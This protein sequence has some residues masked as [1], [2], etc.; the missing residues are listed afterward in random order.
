[1]V[2]S[3]SAKLSWNG[4][5]AFPIVIYTYEDVLRYFETIIHVQMRSEHI[6]CDSTILCDTTTSTLSNEAQLKRF[7]G[8]HVLYSSNR[9]QEC[10]RLLQVLLYTQCHVTSV[11]MSCDLECKCPGVM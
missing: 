4:I 11:P 3:V 2:S 9:A 10:L 5:I 1:M 8:G 7:R 6:F